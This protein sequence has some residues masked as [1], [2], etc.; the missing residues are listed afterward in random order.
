MKEKTEIYIRRSQLGW[1]VCQSDKFLPKQPAGMPRVYA[2][3]TFAPEVVGLLV[4]D[5]IQMKER[6]KLRI[7]IEKW[8]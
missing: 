5:V 2:S 4:S 3:A 8:Q 1:H 7:T 6:D